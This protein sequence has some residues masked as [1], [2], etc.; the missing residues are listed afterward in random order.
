MLF[1]VL[2]GLRA[3]RA[4]PLRTALSTLG[5]VIGVGAL[6][7]VLAM[8]DGVERFARQ[9]IERSTDLLVLRASPRTSRSVDGLLVR[10]A[11]FPTFTAADAE[12]LQAALGRA[13]SVYL[14]IT[15][16]VAVRVPGDSAVRGVIVSGVGAVP[17]DLPYTLRAGRLLEPA[18]LA[19]GEPV[20]VFPAPLAAALGLGLGDS[21][22]L[23][24]VPFQIVGLVA[25]ADSAARV[26][27]VVPLR[28]VARALAPLPAPPPALALRVGA[29]EEVPI[30]RARV[31]AWLATRWADWRDRV[32]V[33]SNERLVEQ[34]RR[35]MLVFKLLMGA[36]TG[37]ALVVGGIGIMNVL[38]ASV[39][40][41]TR[42]IGV[43]R[44]AGAR[45]R[46]LLAQFLAES[47]A[48]TGTGAAA[49]V[50][51][52]LAVA[53]GVAALMRAQTDAPIHIAVT[54]STVAVAAGAAIVVGLVFGMYPAVRAARLAPID[55]IR[56][57]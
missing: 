31:E 47:V 49:G 39:T 10:V 57:E 42:E 38:L 1:S 50:V 22:L 21:V 44:A 43:R 6:V 24:P 55:A 3:L 20:V 8:G 15:G 36:I 11:D 48:I 32:E 4:N 33:Q 25:G 40:E 14:G 19:A 51:V 35:G 45:R 56:H 5:V 53:A 54:G 23:G 52:G 37:I 16:G 12:A 27:A 7:S 34:A 41:R 46:D 29:I 2:V 9:E 28:A 17:R 13:A 30:V 18:D 26:P